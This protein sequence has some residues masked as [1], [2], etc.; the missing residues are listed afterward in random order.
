MTV[1]VEVRGADGPL[2]RGSAEILKA[3]TADH[4][5]RLEFTVPASEVAQF[6]M[7]RGERVGVHTTAPGPEL[8]AFIYDF[9]FD[10]SAGFSGFSGT[11]VIQL[12]GN[13][14][15]PKPGA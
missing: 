4:N 15:P 8:T 7:R 10:E 5:W 3:T 1:E 12:A 9:H 11:G 14:P 13:G 6:Q 2:F